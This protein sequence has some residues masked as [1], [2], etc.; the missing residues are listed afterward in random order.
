MQRPGMR[1]TMSAHERGCFAPD[2]EVLSV[3]E[4]KEM[5]WGVERRDW[6][7]LIGGTIVSVMMGIAVA[8][9]IVLYIQVHRH[10]GARKPDLLDTKGKGR[11]RAEVCTFPAV[12]LY[13]V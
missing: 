11:E 2:G 12:L 5:E 4:W 3:E 9:S 13:H 6:K 8:V 10:G 1:G 7:W